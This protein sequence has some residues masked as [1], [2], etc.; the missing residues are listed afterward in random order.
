MTECVYTFQLATLYM[1]GHHAARSTHTTPSRAARQWGNPHTHRAARHAATPRMLTAFACVCREAV[2]AGTRTEIERLTGRFYTVIPH[3][4]GRQRPPLIQTED[5][6]KAKFEMC[7]VLSDIE[8]AQVL[9][10]HSW[11]P[12]VAANA[13]NTHLRLAGQRLCVSETDR[14][15]WPG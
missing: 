7:N 11:C 4:F 1:R 6:V 9:S 15:V 3:S 14:P 5:Q 13:L 8:T 10:R 2:K 12:V